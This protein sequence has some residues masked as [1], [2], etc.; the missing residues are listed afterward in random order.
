MQKLNGREQPINQQIN[1]HMTDTRTL[2]QRRRIMQ[3]VGIKNTGPEIVIRKLLHAYMYRFRLHRKDLPGK[4]DIV[5]PKRRKIIMV[6]GCYWH[7]HG[8][9]KGKLPKSRLAYW[10]PKIEANRKRDGT[11]ELALRNLGWEVLTVWQCETRDHVQLANLLT[12]FLGPSKNSD[13]H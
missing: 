2:E 11:K 7:G 1:R 9:D 5:F 10:G 8:C 13:R 12:S 3:A 4:P 6:H